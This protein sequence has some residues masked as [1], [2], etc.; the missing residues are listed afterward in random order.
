MGVISYSPLGAGFLTGKYQPGA[1]IPAGTR[2]DIKPGH[3][4][5]YFSEH[6]FRVVTDLRKI[7]ERIGRPMA[8]LALSWVIRRPNITSVLIGARNIEQ[9]DQAFH[10]LAAPWDDAIAAEL[11]QLSAIAD[12]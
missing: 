11:D 7:A 3:Q 4:R 8:Q 6:S 1:P 2:F 9:V 12:P 5:I 10:A